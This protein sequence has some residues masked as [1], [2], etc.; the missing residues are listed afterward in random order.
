VHQQLVVQAE[1]DLPTRPEAG[2]HRHRP[3][4][5]QLC[6]GTLDHG[7]AGVAAWSLSPTHKYFGR[8]VD[9]TGSFNL[10]FAIAGCLPF[11]ALICI[12]LFWNRRGNSSETSAED[13]TT[14]S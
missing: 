9:N 4:L 6:R 12:W 1:H 14:N 5:E 2:A 10:G 13:A 8:L 11:L 7:V 3:P